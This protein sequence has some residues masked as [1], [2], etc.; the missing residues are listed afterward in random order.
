MVLLVMNYDAGDRC[1][2]EWLI[3]FSTS[4]VR[5]ISISIDWLSEHENKKNKGI[6]I[7]EYL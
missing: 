1:A 7:K 3:N 6:T 4:D 2:W 5:G